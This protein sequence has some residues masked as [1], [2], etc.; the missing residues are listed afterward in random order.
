MKEKIKES[1]RILKG[2]SGTHSPSIFTLL[3]EVPEIEVKIDACFLSNPYA[4]DLFMKYMENDLIK[5]G[6]LR[7]VLEYYPPQNQDIAKFV[8]KAIGVK[9]ENIFIANGA[10]E[11]IQEVIHSFTIKKIALI[12]P[13]FSSY[14]EFA[15]DKHEVVYFKLNKADDFELD[16]EKFIEFIRL[17]KPDTVAIINPNNPNGGYIPAEQL[18]R[19]IEEMSD[20]QNVVID[21]SFVHFAYEDVDFS[22]ISSEDLIN[23]HQ[24]LIIVKSMSK[25]FGIAGVRAGYAVMSEERVS[26]LL[27]NGFLWNVSGLTDYFFKVYSSGDFM[28]EYNVVRKKYIMNT[29]MFLSEL[30]TVNENIKVYPSKANFALIELLHGQSSFD[31]AMDL[32]IDDGIYVRDCSDKVGLEG[33]FIR[34]A[35]RTFEENLKIIEAIKN[36]AILKH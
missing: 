22:Q 23:K 10:I 16:V 31:F 24:N 11:V 33:E 19:L 25:D 14:Y 5:S 34:V 26:K 7:E 4:T 20:I 28:S 18:A 2:E 8:S 3:D 32:L 15:S 1:I 30:K 21:E 29:I 35:S 9:K 12:I 13:T 36:R 27:R 6:K 17:E